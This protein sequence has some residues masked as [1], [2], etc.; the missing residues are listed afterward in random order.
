[1]I[2][3]VASSIFGGS[4]KVAP[5]GKMDAALDAIATD[6]W[7]KIRETLESQQTPE[8]RAFRKNLEKGYG[9]ASP[10]HKVRLFDESNKEEDI[11]VKF[12]RD[13]ASWCPYCQKVWLWL[14]EKPTLPL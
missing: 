13:S 8:E 1:M 12:Y 10:M 4:N 5:N 2:G 6:S 9:G 14:E 7:S 3:D 11:Q